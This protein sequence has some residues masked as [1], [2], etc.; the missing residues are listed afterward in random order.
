MDK[1]TKSCG[2]MHLRHLR[3][4]L[5]GTWTMARS[6]GTPTIIMTTMIVIN[7]DNNNDNIMIMISS[8]S[9]DKDCK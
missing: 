3:V 7:N 9:N 4:V 6:T 2:A 5:E 1:P 8:N